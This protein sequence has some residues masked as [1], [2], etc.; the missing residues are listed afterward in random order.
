MQRPDI[1]LMDNILL[2]TQ[3]PDHCRFRSNKQQNKQTKVSERAN[4]CMVCNT[5][6]TNKQTNS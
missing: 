3:M 4:E 1:Q 5:Q 2:Y 6:Q